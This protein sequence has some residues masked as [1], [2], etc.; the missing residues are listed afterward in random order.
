[1][2]DGELLGFGLIAWA[3]CAWITHVIVCIHSASWALLFIGSIIF[4]IS[5]LHGT[6]VW[7]G[8]F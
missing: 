8:I 4:P 2:N 6:G 5:W 7:L 3:V 1:M